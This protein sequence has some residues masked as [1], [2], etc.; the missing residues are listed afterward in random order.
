MPRYLV[1]LAGLMLAACSS[2]G[3][4]FL[5]VE[6]VAIAHDGVR[7]DVYVAR[8][9]VQLIRM[10]STL[11]LS[12]ASLSELYQALVVR[13]TGC[14]VDRRTVSMDHSVMTARLICP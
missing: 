10:G 2:P 9:Q 4:G 11:G 7:H 14:R 13:A 6:P 1:A 5:G 8:G 3:V 12:E